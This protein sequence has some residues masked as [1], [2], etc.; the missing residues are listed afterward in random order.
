MSDKR[1]DLY[2]EL[3]KQAPGHKVED[4][5]ILSSRRYPPIRYTGHNRF[6]WWRNGKVKYRAENHYHLHFGDCSPYG[7][8]GITEVPTKQAI[9]ILGFL[10]PLG[11]NQYQVRFG[12]HE[13]ASLVE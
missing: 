6:G 5:L 13:I 4:T 11:S 1:L 7:N 8:H 3:R 9:E 10:P 12:G 2:K